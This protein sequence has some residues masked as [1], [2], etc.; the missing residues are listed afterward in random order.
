MEASCRHDSET[1]SAGILINF[2]TDGW[3]L[4]LCSLLSFTQNVGNETPMVILLFVVI[5]RA[6]RMKT[7][8]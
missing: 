7:A 5:I 1:Q 4:D 6:A 2:D 8:H 3:Q